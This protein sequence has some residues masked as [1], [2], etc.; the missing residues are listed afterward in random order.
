MYRSL[1]KK[2]C[3]VLKKKIGKKKRGREKK[4]RMASAT[5]IVKR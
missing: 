1:R 2:V 4:K 3:F 5:D